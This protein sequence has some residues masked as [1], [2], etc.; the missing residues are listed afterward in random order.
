MISRRFFLSTAG[1]CVASGF[2]PG[3]GFAAASSL[4]PMA[5]VQP[6]TDRY[7]GQ[8]IVDSYRWMENAADP[9]WLPFLRGQNAY[10]REV[11]DAIPGRS[12]LQRRI[13]ELSSSTGSAFNIK[14]SGP[15]LF[16]LKRLAGSS[17][18]RLYTRNLEGGAERL[19]VDPD[20]WPGEANAID[21][22]FSVSPNGRLLLFGIDQGGREMPVYQL[23]DTVTGK[24]L[25]DRI[26]R[27]FTGDKPSI[28]WLP[29]SSGFFYAQFAEGRQPSAANMFEDTPLR[30]HH[31]GDA[32]KGDAYI[33]RRDNSSP[34]PLQPTE[35]LMI[36]TSPDSAT[37]ILTVGDGV[38]RYFRLYSA[39]VA[40]V[41]AGTA[42][43]TAIAGYEDQIAD[44]ALRGD[45][46]YLVTTKDNPRGSLRRTSA[47]K[48]SLLTA[49][50]RLAA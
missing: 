17:K 37:A 13:L 7:F 26:D 19:L 10:A 42:K 45:S 39:P 15:N 43:W 6:V 29:D 36:T 49:A 33:V 14:R 11:L 32:Q 41:V 18:P 5:K 25:D 23:I 28:H 38:G 16:Y 21:T 22:E 48:P 35:W 30:Y 40:A 44:F 12:G 4:P 34:F 47:R 20:T 3:F 2:L 46:L 9:D 1:V 8:E 31:I 50:R 27:S 24:L